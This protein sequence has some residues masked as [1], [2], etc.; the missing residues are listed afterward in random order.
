MFVSR[1][2]GMSE[3]K[4]PEDK[5]YEAVAAIDAGDVPRLKALLDAHPELLSA[6]L[7][8]PS[9]KLRAQVGNALDGFFK[10]PYL[11]WFVAEDPVRNR[12]LPHNISEVTRAIIH[13]CGQHKVANLQEQLD[14]AL[15]LVAWSSVAAQCGVQL[16]LIDE[17]INAGAAPGENA[18][19]ALVNGHF[20]AAE[21]LIKRG[22]TLTLPAALCLERWDALSQLIKKA[23]PAGRQFSFVLAALNGKA[24]AVKRMLENGCPVNE[25]SA[26]LYSHGTALHHAVCSGS[27]ETVKVLVAAGAD[28]NRQD[29]VWQGTPL[30]WA[31]H[32]V[33]SA[34]PEH[35]A[36]YAE[37][38][39]YLR[40]LTGA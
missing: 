29:S 21:H 6:R 30:G 28:L 11:L 10:R 19:N 20:A 31:N 35:R 17:L 12:R 14:T 33:E 4:L 26:D 9:A 40:G 16:E 15:R 7:E 1:E 5:F 39:A 34:S 8:K 37:I 2:E 3:S 36:K 32:Y 38:A 25:P 24:A 22:G 23:S 27:L 18:N 13:A